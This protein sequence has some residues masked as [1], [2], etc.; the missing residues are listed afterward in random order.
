MRYE[1]S[2]VAGRSSRKYR[3][4]LWRNEIR[5]FGWLVRADCAIFGA[6]GSREVT[7]SE[8]GTQRASES[9]WKVRGG[10]SGGE[11]VVDYGRCIPWELE[12]R[13]DRAAQKWLAGESS[14]GEK[15]KE[16]VGGRGEIA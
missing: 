10:F 12:I 5:P 8:D 7:S 2:D 1:L 16:T 9:A 13:P 11:E 15:R 14:S 4:A 3:H 6:A